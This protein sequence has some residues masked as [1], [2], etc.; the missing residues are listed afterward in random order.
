[1]SEGIGDT[2]RISLTG[3]LENEV[4]SGISLLKVLNLRDGIDIVSCPTC[5]RAKIDVKKLSSLVENKTA[6]VRKNIKVAIM[7]CEVNGP[8]EARDA[9]I[10]IAG[11]GNMAVLFEKGKIVAKGSPSQMLKLLLKKLDLDN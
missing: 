6:K 3:E 4:I 1:M 7:G 10:G 11:S 8:G 5:G 9:D 2:I